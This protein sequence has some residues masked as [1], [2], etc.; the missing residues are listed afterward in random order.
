VNVEVE[1][2]VLALLVTATPIKTFAPIDIVS[3]P[4]CDQEVPVLDQ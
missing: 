2:T 4:S 3:E 1:E